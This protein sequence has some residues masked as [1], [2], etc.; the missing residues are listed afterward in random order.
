MLVHFAAQDPQTILAS[1]NILAIMA[2]IIVTLAGV[3]IY[4]ARKLDVQQRESA[5]E[6]K[7]LNKLLYSEQKAH[8][9]DYREMSNDYREVVQAN[10]QTS[11]L[12][13]E[14]IEVLKGRQP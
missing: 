8:T 2:L 4:L 9:L 12:I 11:A 14:K 1:G 13:G 7:E 3:I 10:T 6:I 5:T